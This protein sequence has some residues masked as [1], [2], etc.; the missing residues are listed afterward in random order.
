MVCIQISNRIFWEILDLMVLKKKQNGL[1]NLLNLME[2]KD[3]AVR[4]HVLRGRLILK[5]MRSSFVCMNSSIAC[6]SEESLKIWRID[7]CAVHS[8]QAELILSGIICCTSDRPSL[9]PPCRSSEAD[10]EWLAA[11]A[12]LKLSETQQ[13][14]ER[15][16]LLMY[17]SRSKMLI[18]WSKRIYQ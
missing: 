11:S 14:S 13:L 17:S 10:R 9:L 6:S 1:E 8:S 15:L 18:G 16:L 2:Q 12:E 7:E 3:W 4:T 5:L